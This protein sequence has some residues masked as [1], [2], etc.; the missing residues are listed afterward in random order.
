VLE[1]E[2]TDEGEFLEEDGIFWQGTRE[3]LDAWKKYK[4]LKA[5]AFVERGYSVEWYPDADNWMRVYVSERQSKR[6]PEITADVKFFGKPSGFG[7]DQGMVSKLCIQRR[8]TNLIAK[9]FGDPWEQLETLFNYDR[10]PDVDRLSEDQT[11]RA[12]YHAILDELN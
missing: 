7:I 10:G 4:Q 12:L 2:M 11:A 9:V 5:V 8:T 6:E 1:P 3:E